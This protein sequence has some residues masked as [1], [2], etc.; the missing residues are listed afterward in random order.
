MNEQ[1]S[2][3]KTYRNRLNYLIRAAER[4]YY[5]DQ[6]SKHKSNLKKSW[7]IIKTIINKSKNR[8]SASEFKCNGKTITNGRQ[9]SDKFN[10]F[11]VNVGSNLTKDIPKSRK[12]PMDY[13]NQEINECFYVMPVTDEET[14]KIIASFKDS[15]LTHICN[16]SF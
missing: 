10:K 11:L 13:I 1:W 8:H 5:Q 14:A 3:Y 16:L 2:K 15:S 9:I 6:I 12:D 4:Q 7:Q